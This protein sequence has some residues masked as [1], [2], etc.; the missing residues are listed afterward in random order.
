[1][2]SSAVPLIGGIFQAGG[3]LSK[4]QDRA[5]ALEDEA[6]ASEKNAAITRQ[7]GKY[8]ADRHSI[9]SQK[10]FGSIE[11]DYAASGVTSDSVSALEVMRESHK[12]SELDR[13]NI[14]YGAEMKARDLEGRAGSARRGAK[15]AIK[16]GEFDAFAALFGAGAEAAGKSE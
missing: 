9:A 14:L 12:N 6:I 16:A 10:Q 4:A 7:A 13:M 5:W 11:A 8:N 15:A 3:S 1:M 2:G